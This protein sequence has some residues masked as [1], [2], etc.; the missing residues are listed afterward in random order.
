MSR[1][2][3][4]SGATGFDECEVVPGDSCDLCDETLVVSVAQLLGDRIPF[5]RADCKIQAG[6]ALLCLQ[7]MTRDAADTRKPW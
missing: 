4:S 1:V 3:A 6:K 5:W 7:L 2:P